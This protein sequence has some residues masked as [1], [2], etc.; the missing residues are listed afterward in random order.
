MEK[1]NTAYRKSKL[2]VLKEKTGI[3]IRLNAT[4]Q[5]RN[6]ATTQ[7]RKNQTLVDKRTEMVQWSHFQSIAFGLTAFQEILLVS[8]SIMS[9]N[10]TISAL[11]ISVFLFLRHFGIHLL[12]E[13]QTSKHQPLNHLY[14]RIH[15]VW[16]DFQNFDHPGGPIALHLAKDRD[17]TVLFESHHLLSKLNMSKILSKYRVEAQVARDLSTIDPRDDESHYKWDNFHDDPF[18]MDVK[19][20]LVSHIGPIA[21]KHNCS[22]YQA[23]KASKERYAF[24]GVLVLAVIST[25]PHYVG[26]CWWTVF[27]F[28]VLVWLLAVNYWHDCLHFSL[29][30]DWR[31]NASLPYLVPI[32]SSPWL[33]YHQHVIGHHAYTNIA[34][35]DPDLAHAPQLM[36]EHK[37]IPWKKIHQNQGNLH[38]FIFLWSVAT[39]LG[40][41][42]IGDLKAN[43]K[44]S[45]N[46]VVGFNKL[47]FSRLFFH[48]TGRLV[49][50]Y[51]A[52]V[53][54]GLT[55]S[56]QKAVVW[57]TVPNILFSFCFMLNSQINHLTLE[58]SN[59]SDTNFLKHQVI[60]AQ[61]F[62][63][64][65]LFCI[66]FSGGLNYQIEH[67][68][69]PFLNHCHLPALGEL[70]RALDYY[71]C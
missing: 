56:F 68:L 11:F 63:C 19:N 28:P 70:Y 51:I 31:T 57:I 38:R 39:N 65:S 54:P 50:V 45:Y 12:D 60:T 20:L 53:W 33:W 35:K 46:N 67:H 8:K 66:I 27:V 55:F 10:F 5:Q 3:K 4:T 69:F 21:K 22:L 13:A 17:A 29:C 18:V 43:L 37:S 6:N 26:G 30:S 62:G 44:L 14:T 58:C 48:I 23:A 41:N 9:T 49:Y 1:A 71:L 7:H 2:V 42:L 24:L 47:S 52:F 40:L 34:M 64:D 36:R 15:G 61:N 16:Y 59:A 25:L 32:F